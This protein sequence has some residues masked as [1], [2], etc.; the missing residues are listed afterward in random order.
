MEDDLRDDLEDS[1]ILLKADKYKQWHWYNQKVIE[2]ISRVLEKDGTLDADVEE[3][4]ITVSS[5]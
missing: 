1:L 5:T 2:D 3:P 4:V